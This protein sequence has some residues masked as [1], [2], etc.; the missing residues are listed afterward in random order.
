MQ[1]KQ[2]KYPGSTTPKKFKRVH[3]AGK[4]MGSIFWDRQGVIMI[5]YLEQCCT[6]KRCILC[7]RIEAATPGNCKK[8]A[9]KTDSRYSTLAGQCPCPHVT[10]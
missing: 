9:R 2:W 8:E 7:M 5:D 4:G 1:S 6:I 10:S 3:S